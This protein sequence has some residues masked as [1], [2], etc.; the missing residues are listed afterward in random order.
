MIQARVE[1][2]TLHLELRADR[3]RFQGTD[4]TLVRKLFPEGDTIDTDRLRAHYQGSGF[5]P[6]GCIRG[7]TEHRLRNLD[8]PLARQR[9]WPRLAAGA[10]VALAAALG[11]MASFTQPPV[12]DPFWYLVSALVAPVSQALAAL[13]LAAGFARAV[14]RPWVPAIMLALLLAGWAVAIVLRS[15]AVGG[16]ETLLGLGAR[17]AAWTGAALG[18][19]AFGRT[20]RLPDAILF[21]K[22]IA[23]ARAWLAR[24][25]ASP[26]PRLKDGWAPWLIALGLS[27]DADRWF[28]AN[29]RAARV[30]DDEQDHDHDRTSSTRSD[31]DR[32]TGGGGLFSGGG[33]SGGWAALG[34]VATSYSPPS[35]SSSDSDSSSSSSSSDSS[36]GGGGGG[37]W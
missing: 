11:L 25:L 17:V 23:A 21:R 1:G 37:G 5:D 14:R 26:T 10:L 12:G 28:S 6:A 24:E 19:F 8:G 13:G 35:S 32:W 22:R 18:V 4:E 30:H 29:P 27:R 16:D 9:R 36:S 34:A 31:P 15:R 20:R 33:A 2:K 7:Q 3:G